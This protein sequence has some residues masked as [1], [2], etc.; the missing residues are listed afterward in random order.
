MWFCQSRFSPRL[1]NNARGESETEVVSVFAVSKCIDVVY[2]SAQHTGG[3]R[4]AELNIPAKRRQRIERVAQT[5]D[6]NES[7]RKKEK[8]SKK[9]KMKSGGNSNEDHRNRKPVTIQSSH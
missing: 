5:E 6:I 8:E 9:K 1:I 4:I 2:G 7:S 3:R